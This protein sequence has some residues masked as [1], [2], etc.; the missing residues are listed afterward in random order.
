LIALGLEKGVVS[1]C[2]EEEDKEEEGRRREKKKKEK[3]GGIGKK[4]SVR[5]EEDSRGRRMAVERK[6]YPKR[7]TRFDESFERFLFEDKM[8]RYQQQ[9]AVVSSSAVATYRDKNERGTTA[10][11]SVASPLAVPAALFIPPYSLPASAHQEEGVV[12]HPTTPTTPSVVALPRSRLRAEVCAV[13]YDQLP[14]SFVDQYILRRSRSSSGYFGVHKVR[15]GYQ[16]QIYA[17]TVNGAKSLM[18]HGIF[19]D[20]RTAAL[21]ATVATADAGIGRTPNGGRSVIE[22]VVRRRVDDEAELLSRSPASP[23]PSPSMLSCSGGC[24]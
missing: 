16:V 3:I 13:C 20:L 24:S 22:E 6:S 8:V 7:S 15:S 4:K 10:S 17:Q 5:V 21:A 9:G 14:A 18:H 11:S 19:A 2:R 23:P 12:V 1:S